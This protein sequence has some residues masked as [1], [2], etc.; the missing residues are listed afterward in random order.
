MLVRDKVPLTDRTVILVYDFENDRASTNQKTNKRDKIEKN[1]G[2]NVG[3]NK[4]DFVSEFPIFFALRT[5]GN[6]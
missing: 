5:E 2:R 1:R 3:L 4:C 6:T